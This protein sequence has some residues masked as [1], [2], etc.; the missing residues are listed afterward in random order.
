MGLPEKKRQELSGRVRNGSS[1]YY[2][3]IA[4][5]LRFLKWAS[6]ISVFLLVLATFVLYRHEMTL[7]NFRYILRYVSLDTGTDYRT[8]NQITYTADP[9]TRYG[10]LKGDLAMVSPT[11]F[12]VYEFTGQE[13]TGDRINYL[14]PALLTCG[15]YALIYDV[16]GK[17]LALYNSNGCLFEKD[18]THGIKHA[19]LRS[20]GVFAV[21]S[22]DSFVSS[23]V[24]VYGQSFEKDYTVSSTD[25]EILAASLPDGTKRLDLL[26]LHASEGDFLVHLRSYDMKSRSDTFACES[27][28]VG[29]YPLRMVSDKDSVA[30]LTDKRIRFYDGELVL[31]AEYDL[32]TGKIES[33]YETED[34]VALT[35]EKDISGRSR[36]RIF[37]RDGREINAEELDV[38]VV[39]F[40]SEGETVYILEREGLGIYEITD[41]GS[42]AL[43]RTEELSEDYG[44]K[45]VFALSGNKYILASDSGAGKF[46]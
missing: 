18:F 20:D 16:T 32:G 42:L 38:R 26:M 28:I 46:E 35:Y 13:L 12:S 34:Y 33:F 15:R 14:N 37:S 43:K 4:D 40:A 21:V 9:E 41:D 2:R 25:K 29:E 8:S 30:V 45:E 1:E 3:R 17:E 44:Y 22:S 27:L 10:Y 31:F 5:G 19:A 6:I 36:I 39:S 7:E 11:D 24:S 23:S